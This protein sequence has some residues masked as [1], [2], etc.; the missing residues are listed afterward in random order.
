MEDYNDNKGTISSSLP[1]ARQARE[2]ALEVSVIYTVIETIKEAIRKG[3][4]SCV[5]EC[6]RN[7]EM[8]PYILQIL[9]NK[10]YIVKILDDDSI[11]FVTYNISW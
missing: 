3:K 7:N 8:Q 2:Y 11:Q 1:T 5:Y 9:R 10:G 4:F 6:L